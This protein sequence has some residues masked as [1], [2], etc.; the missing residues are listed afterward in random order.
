MF[1]RKTFRYLSF[2]WPKLRQ[3]ALLCE[4]SLKSW[5]VST[6]P[7]LQPA[8]CSLALSMG[9]S[10]PRAQIGTTASGKEHI[11]SAEHRGHPKSS[12]CQNSHG[13][14][15]V[16]HT[17]LTEIKTPCFGTLCLCWPSPHHSHL[18][19]LCCTG[20]LTPWVI[21]TW[22]YTLKVASPGFWQLTSEIQDS[23]GVKL[24]LLFSK[25]V[26]TNFLYL[27][28]SK[29]IELCK[30]LLNDIFILTLPTLH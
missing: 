25:H 19:L 20:S 9:G 4:G 11:A 26:K 8:G 22:I 27:C 1:S 17:F 18:L 29:I 7:L 3:V 15:T 10:S 2:A 24:P 30:V 5:P 12:Y 6:L 21:F 16:L 28:K 23:L 14:Q 13:Q